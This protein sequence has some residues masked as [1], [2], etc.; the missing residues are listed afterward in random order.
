MGM[1]RE[2]DMIEQQVKAK[3]ATG[4]MMV[5]GILK[6]SKQNTQK[7]RHFI[8]NLTRKFSPKNCIFFGMRFFSLFLPFF[9]FL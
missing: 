2:A 8:L 6:K 1:H 7:L 9:F 3:Q 4:Q 5:A